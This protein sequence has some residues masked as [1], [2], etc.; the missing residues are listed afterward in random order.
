M[1]VKMKNDNGAVGIN[2]HSFSGRNIQIDS[3]KVI[4][5]G[6][7]Q[8]GDLVGEITV[9]VYG[10]VDSLHTSS[11]DVKAESVNKISTEAGSVVCGNV[12]GSVSTQSGAVVCG[13]V[14]GSINTMSGNIRQI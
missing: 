9:T 14:S 3:N 13:S 10:D 1:K 2:G 4:V 7:T 11:G 12:S 6:V 8:D 5:D